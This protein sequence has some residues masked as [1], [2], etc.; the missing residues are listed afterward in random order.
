[1]YDNI[2]MFG[3]D[4][5]TQDNAVLVIKQALVDHVAVADPEINLAATLIRLSRLQ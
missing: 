1:M 2:S 4:E 3:K 5:A